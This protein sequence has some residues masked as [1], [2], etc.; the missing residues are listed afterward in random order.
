MKERFIPRKRRV[1][2]L[3]RE[4]KEEVHEFI[5]E[6]LRKGYCYKTRVQ[7]DF[8]VRVRIEDRNKT[9]VLLLVYNGKR[10]RDLE[11]M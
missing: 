8:R 10:A 3:S 7:T 2:L 4:K 6:Q 1:Y 11:V 9:V 5:S